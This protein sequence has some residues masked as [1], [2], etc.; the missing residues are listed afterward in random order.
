MN[1]QLKSQ[2]GSSVRPNIPLRKAAFGTEHRRAFQTVLA[3]TVASLV[4]GVGGIFLQAHFGLIRPSEPS[5][6]PAAIAPSQA[7][8]SVSAPPLPPPPKVSNDQIPVT[9][10]N[11]AIPSEV[12][13]VVL[14]FAADKPVRG[15]LS[16]ARN[17][18]KDEAYLHGHGYLGDELRNLEAK[19]IALL[20]N[21]GADPDSVAKEREVFSKAIDSTMARLNILIA[22]QSE[23]QETKDRSQVVL[24]ELE[25]LKAQLP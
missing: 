17:V 14:K 13:Q 23:T 19:S 18:L 2:V 9:E 15:A 16:F 10:E 25:L 22:R 24:S 4:G 11:I 5:S 6:A 1:S 3:L 21:D 20:V 7:I 12:I 8:T